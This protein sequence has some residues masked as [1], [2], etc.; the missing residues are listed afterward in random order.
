MKRSVDDSTSAPS[1]PTIGGT[2]TSAGQ[3]QPESATVVK[4]R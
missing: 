2:T 4:P 1:T 3:N